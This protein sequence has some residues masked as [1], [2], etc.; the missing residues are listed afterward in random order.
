MCAG[1]A[2][3]LPPGWAP[4]LLPSYLGDA[5][6]WVQDAHLDLV[7]EKQGRMRAAGIHSWITSALSTI[8]LPESSIVLS[9]VGPLNNNCL[10]IKLLK[11]IFPAFR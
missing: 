11:L 2:N 4:E 10:T 9:S 5:D 6:P 1:V 7:H 8:V 3:I